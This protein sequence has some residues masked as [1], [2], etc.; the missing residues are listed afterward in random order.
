MRRTGTKEWADR[1][2]NIQVGCEHNCGYCYGRSMA[3]RFKRITNRSDWKNPREIGFPHVPHN[4]NDRTV[5][6]FSTHDITVN[7]VDRAI[8]HILEWLIWGWKVL[9][10]TK[11]RYIVIRRLMD[12]LCQFKDRITF[13]FTIGSTIDKKLAYWEP[14]A[15]T[16]D[17]RFRSLT[18]A[19]AKDWKTSVSIEPILDLHTMDLVTEIY[20]YVNDT[21]WI[22]L[23]KQGNQR[24]FIDPKQNPEIVIDHLNNSRINLID[25]TLEPAH[26]R[27]LFKEIKAFDKE[28][29][30]RWKDSIQ[31]ILG[32]DEFG[33]KK[34]L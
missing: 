2:S 11:P 34:K 26:V 7:N 27:R 21:I 14:G 28:K 24:I 1:T 12:D 20:P 4:G 5:M 19:Y 13:R 25:W 23:M 3:Y 16:Y 15:P 6:L 9:I 10:V 33:K 29:K 32:V 8:E 31:T 17:D 22:G 30:V 18:A